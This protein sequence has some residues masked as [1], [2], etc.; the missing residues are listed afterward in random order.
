MASSYDP[1]LLK[2]LQDMIKGENK[3]LREGLFSD[4]IEQVTKVI[5]AKLDERAKQLEDK[6]MAAVRA[7]GERTRVLEAQ[8]SAEAGSADGGDRK[9]RAMSTP[10]TAPSSATSVAPDPQVVWI[11]G[12]PRELLAT[13]LKKFA[14]E[15][16]AGVSVD[17]DKHAVVKSYN[18]ENKCSISFDSVFMAH[19]FLD[20]C[21]EN[22]IMYE[23]TKLRVRPDRS[24]D[25]RQRNRILG[26]LWSE[27]ATKIDL[28]KRAIGQNG[29]KGKV[30]VSEKDGESVAIVFTLT[31]HGAN[32]LHIE[33]NAEACAAIGLTDEAARDIVDRVKAKV[34]AAATNERR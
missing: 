5:N 18:L 33:I 24:A 17:M 21:R 6:L 4:I 34:A 19:R 23:G 31:A 14:N 10:S 32:D 26:G 20:Y 1:D 25:A 29:P 22:D 13:R 16:M 27:L 15:V 7:V 30:F 9:R 2:N 3:A 12:F 11:L 8:L 28:T